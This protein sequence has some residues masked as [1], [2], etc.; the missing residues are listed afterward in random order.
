MN[1]KCYMKKLNEKLELEMMTSFLI[2][3]QKTEVAKLELEQCRLNLIKEKNSL[4]VMFKI[5]VNLICIWFPDS[6][7]EIQISF[8]LFERVSRVGRLAC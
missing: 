8:S 5:N 4:R 6:Q 7:R 3:I 2:L 1:F